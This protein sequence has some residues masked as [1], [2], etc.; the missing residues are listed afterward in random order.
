MS[1]VGIESGVD[2]EQNTPNKKAHMNSADKNL[3]SEGHVITKVDSHL[4]DF[5]HASA[6]LICA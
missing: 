6:C 4:N 1:S 3:I 5:Y 2:N